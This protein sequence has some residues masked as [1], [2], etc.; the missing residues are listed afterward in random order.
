MKRM[1]DELVPSKCAGDL[2]LQEEHRLSRDHAV[3]HCVSANVLACRIER[4]SR[5]KPN[6][7]TPASTGDF[8]KTLLGVAAP[9][10]AD[11]FAQAA[12]VSGEPLHDRSGARR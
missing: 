7:Q 4:L 12:N 2:V 11:P 8:G 5:S 10:F 9:D 6:D 1:P 3:D